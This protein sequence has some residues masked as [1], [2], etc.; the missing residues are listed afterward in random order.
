MTWVLFEKGWLLNCGDAFGPKLTLVRL[1]AEGS[2]ES[3]VPD[4]V[5]FPHD[6]LYFAATI[7]CRDKHHLRKA[8]GGGETGFRPPLLYG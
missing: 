8:R 1:A 3:G 2:F 6:L 5:S 4:I 7:R